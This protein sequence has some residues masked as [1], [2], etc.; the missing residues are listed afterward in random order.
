[1]NSF[2]SLF[3]R[4][5]HSMKALGQRRPIRN[6]RGYRPTLDHLEERRLLAASF[7]AAAEPAGTVDV[8]LVPLANV[9]AGTPE[10]VTFGVPFT[11][12]SVTNADLGNVRVLKNGA[13]IPA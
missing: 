8:Q 10:V 13:E 2:T 6:K 11:L 5:R 7:F 12:G 9:A 4:L 3:A 1:M